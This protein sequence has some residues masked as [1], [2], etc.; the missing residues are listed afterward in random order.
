MVTSLAG[1]QPRERAAEPAE[2]LTKA[3][4]TAPLQRDKAANPSPPS[5][6]WEAAR[7]PLAKV[8]MVLRGSHVLNT[9]ALATLLWGMAKGLWA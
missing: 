7:L 5:I 3:V 9:S 1:S 6:L 8:N 2:H 4:T